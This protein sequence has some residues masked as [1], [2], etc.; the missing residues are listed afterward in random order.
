MDTFTSLAIV[1]FAALIHASFQLS[2]SVLTL[3]S[4]HAIGAKKS[5]ARLVRLTTSY[6]TG[7]GV[8]TLLIVTG[9]IVP[10]CVFLLRSVRNFA[11]ARGSQSSVPLVPR[12]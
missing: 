8:M 4:G 7:A 6:T 10:W 12:R 5:H 1:G 9:S 2:V 3:L 11:N